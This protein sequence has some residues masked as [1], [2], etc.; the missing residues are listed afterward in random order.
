MA[1]PKRVYSCGQCGAEH[2][3]WQGQCADCGAW[4]ALSEV[5]AEGD[6]TRR[7][8]LAGGAEIARLDSIRLDRTE[9]SPSGFAEFD[10]VLGGGLVPGSVVLIGGEPGIG[11]STLLL[12]VLASVSQSAPVCYVTGE[13]SLDQVAMRADRLG[14][15]SAPVQMM[16]E[17]HV[18]TIIASLGKDPPA[19]LVIDS[20]QTLYTDSLQS[21]PGSVSQLRES[22]AQLV[23]FAKTRGIATLLVGHV[24][25]EGTL[26]GPRVLEHM[27]DTVLYFEGDRNHVFLGYH[28]TLGQ[29]GGAGGIIDHADI[30]RR[31]AGDHLL[32]Q[33]G[34]FGSQVSTQFLNVFEIG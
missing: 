25:K 26:A 4:N 34:L 6:R 11:K 13:E 28:T 12:S 23:R 18:E 9:R 3:Q 32:E 24:T 31:Q 10:R 16:A 21:A 22:A 15:R 14:V 5:R 30:I 19:V 1:K 17:T 2:R 7:A 27:V 33:A 8:A 29:S 20:V